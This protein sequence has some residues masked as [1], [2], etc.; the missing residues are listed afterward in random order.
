MATYTKEQIDL[1]NEIR[2]VANLNEEG[3]LDYDGTIYYA[4]LLEQANQQNIC[5]F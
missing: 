1:A 4:E 5:V 2:R 3:K